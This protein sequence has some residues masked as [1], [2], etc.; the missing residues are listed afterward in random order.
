MFW[1]PE[2]N[3]C[4]GFFLAVGDYPLEVF[5]VFRAFYTKPGIASLVASEHGVTNI[6]FY[7]AHFSPPVRYS[8]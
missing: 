4:L 3:D 6:A 8:L 1:T 2:I 5:A 7:Y